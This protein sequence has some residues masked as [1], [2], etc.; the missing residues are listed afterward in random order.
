METKTGLDSNL[1][2]CCTTDEVIELMLNGYSEQGALISDYDEVNLYNSSFD[3]NIL[4]EY[5]VETV[6][7][8]K[9][10]ETWFM[11][12]KYKSIDVLEYCINLCKSDNEILRVCEE[13]KMYEERDLI[14]L[15]RYF[16]FL[17][18]I[19]R[20]YSIIWGVGR[21]SSVASYILYLIGIHKVDSIKYNLDI[22]EFL[23]E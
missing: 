6:D 13:F 4:S 16:I 15:L 2:V 11:P 18:D 8:F 17:V 5:S 23:K 10:A 19:M 9:R 3:Q 20:Q 21:G 1:N 14:N 7:I 22:K 12:E